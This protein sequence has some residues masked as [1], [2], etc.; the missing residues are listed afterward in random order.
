MIQFRRC[1]ISEMLIY[2]V[3]M[4]I[5]YFMHP[6]QQISYHVYYEVKRMIMAKKRSNILIFKKKM[7]QHNLA[8]MYCTVLNKHVVENV[9]TTSQQ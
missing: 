1:K 6:K 7:Y 5:C 3:A 4:E 2:T 8:Y 9:M